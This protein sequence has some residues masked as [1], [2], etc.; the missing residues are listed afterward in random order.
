MGMVTLLGR[1]GSSLG[2]ARAEQQHSEQGAYVDAAWEA[3]GAKLGQTDGDE[4][5]P[6]AV[7]KVVVHAHA[8]GNPLRACLYNKKSPKRRQL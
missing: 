8:V 7:E 2:E 4:A 5:L 3:L 1:L 6:V